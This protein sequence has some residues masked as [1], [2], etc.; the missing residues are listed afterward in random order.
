MDITQQYLDTVLSYNGSDNTD[1]DGLSPTTRL[2]YASGPTYREAVEQNVYRIPTQL[3]Y[4]GQL[5]LSGIENIYVKINT[6]P[7]ETDQNI[8]I[9][10][11]NWECFLVRD[12]PETDAFYDSAE[13]NPAAEGDMPIYQEVRISND[14]WLGDLGPNVYMK[15][16]L[17]DLGTDNIWAD[18]NID[19]ALYQKNKIPNQYSEMFVPLKGNFTFG[20]HSRNSKRTNM[21]LALTIGTDFK[22]RDE[23]T[24]DELKLIYG[25]T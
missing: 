18:T 15:V 14:F 1:A 23:M 10:E 19:T 3:M 16:R 24:N 13:F 25:G 2:N 4:E 11:R 8:C 6:D 7:T 22:T 21:R 9:E 20:I 12:L 5:G 17:D